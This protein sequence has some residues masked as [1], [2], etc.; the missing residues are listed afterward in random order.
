MEECREKPSE[1]TDENIESLQFVK[2]NVRKY[3]L[4]SERLVICPKIYVFVYDYMIQLLLPRAPPRI[5]AE[6]CQLFKLGKTAILKRGLTSLNPLRIFYAYLSSMQI[7][8]L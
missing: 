6:N 5:K 2:I 1:T 7:V 4:F 8:N 3:K